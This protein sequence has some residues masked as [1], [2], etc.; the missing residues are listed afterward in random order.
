[1]HTLFH[2]Q[3]FSLEMSPPH[4]LFFCKSEKN[5][6]MPINHFSYILKCN[7]LIGKLDEILLFWMHF[8]QSM[9]FLR[10]VSSGNISNIIQPRISATYVCQLRFSMISKLDLKCHSESSSVKG[11]FPIWPHL[12]LATKLSII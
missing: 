3:S 7:Y 8:Q 11:P 12:F 2:T 5:N 10:Y 1:M 9:H 4:L 6:H